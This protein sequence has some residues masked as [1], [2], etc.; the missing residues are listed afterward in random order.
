MPRLNVAER[1]NAIGRLEAGQSQISV[2]TSLNVSQSTISRI[3]DTFI[4]YRQR[5]SERDFPRSDRPR[6]TTASQDR[7]IYLHF[8]CERFT[9]ASSTASAI[10]GELRIFD[11]NVSS[12]LHDAGR[13]VKAVV[14]TPRHRQNRLLWGQGQRVRP[15]KRWRTDLFSNKSRLLLQWADGGAWVYKCRNEYFAAN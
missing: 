12:C 14:L 9:T 6:V 13:S 8:K 4:I 2:A 5:A 7:Y 15:Q 10:P 3:W 1:N 11:Q